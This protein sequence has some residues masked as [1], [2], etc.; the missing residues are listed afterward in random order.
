MSFKKTH[1]YHLTLQ[2]TGNKGTGTSAY[3]EYSRSYFI[4]KENK[5]KIMGS[6]D[7]AFL[8][9]PTAY[10]PEELFLSSLSSCHMLWYLHLCAEQG[11]QVMSY[12]DEPEGFMVEN[13]NGSGA[14]TSVVLKPFVQILKEDQ[15]SLAVELHQKAA[16]FCFIANSV[17][18]KVEHRP[19]ITIWN[20][21]H[22]P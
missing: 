21:L 6:S 14:F 13:E 2:W 11:I 3:K 19:D 4:D 16:E 17:N 12:R 1:R 18:F 8:G 9:D 20:I 7:P 5:P 15:I 22:T 10:N